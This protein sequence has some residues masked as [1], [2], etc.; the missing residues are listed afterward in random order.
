MTRPSKIEIPAMESAPGGKT[1]G[2][3]DYRKVPAYI[4]RRTCLRALNASENAL[5][6]WETRPDDPLPR[7]KT[8]GGKKVFYEINELFEWHYRNRLHKEFGKGGPAQLE[9]SP[10]NRPKSLKDPVAKP[11]NTNEA[12]IRLDV[13]KAEAQEIKNEVTR[14]ALA[15][16]QLLEDALSDLGAQLSA[17]LGAIPSKL[18]KKYSWLKAA[19]LNDVESEIAEAL[20]ASSDCRLKLPERPIELEDYSNDQSTNSEATSST[21]D[22]SPNFW[23]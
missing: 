5:R 10:G 9:V 1:N 18:K 7:Y 2:T 12:K 11:K 19:Q 13:A 17:I 21:E 3:N 14:G 8:K 4:D 22:P 20:N 16:I 23:L 15:P 6:N